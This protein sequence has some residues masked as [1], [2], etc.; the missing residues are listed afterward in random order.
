MRIAVCEDNAV[1][2]AFLCTFIQG[3]C[4]R[5]AYVCEIE[6]FESGEALLARFEPDRFPVVLLDIFLPGMTGMDLARRIRGQD[7]TCAILFVTVSTDHALEGFGVM[8]AGYVVKPLMEE[9]LEKALSACRESFERNSRVLAVPVSGGELALPLTKIRFVEVFDKR[10]IFHMGDGAVEAH[11]TLD[12]VEKALGGLPFLRCHRSYIVNLN[13]VEAAGERDLRL[14][15]GG[16][17]PI[18]KHG[19]R[20]IRLAYA[21][22]LAGAR[23]APV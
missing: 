13:H 20:E 19:A 18:R 3:F 7:G 22:F 2:R 10:T 23:E 17:V 11:I 1:D 8:A 5:N 12:K 9:K 4:E 14:R 15:G 21:R 16:T 6:T